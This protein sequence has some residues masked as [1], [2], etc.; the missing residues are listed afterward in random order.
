MKYLLDSNTCIGW[1]RSNQPKLVARIAQEH[2]LNLSICSIVLGELLYGAER[3]APEHRANNR[4]RVDQ[5]RQQFI[6]IPFDDS[7]AEQY[8]R[9]RA[10]LTAKGTPIGPNDLLIASIAMSQGRILI[11]H[12]TSEFARVPGLSIEDWQ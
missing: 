5:L 10:Y 2:P 1:L 12:N 3:A 8:G 9:L 6:S 11:T 7:A 4:W